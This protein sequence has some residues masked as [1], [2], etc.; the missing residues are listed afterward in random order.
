MV[1]RQK[2]E[3]E[4]D[5]LASEGR[6]KLA[7]VEASR[8]RANELMRRP[9]P[10]RLRWRVSKYGAPGVNFA[11][12][13]AYSRWPVLGALV[14]GS[15]LAIWG[16]AGGFFLGAFGTF[17]G[18][19]FS[20]IFVVPLLARAEVRR[21]RRWLAS[22]PF[23]VTGYFETLGLEEVVFHARVSAKGSFE[24]AERATILGLLGH[25]EA[26]QEPEDG[27]R[28]V[29]VSVSYGTLVITRGRLS[30]GDQEVRDWVRGVIERVLLPRQRAR[31]VDEVRVDHAG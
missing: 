29:T 18:G 19:W 23:P 5:A 13:W 7:L 25:V 14:A 6:Q 1:E 30:D 24:E 22:L 2:A 16:G 15:V 26:N 21:E 10:S 17:M 31:P 9:S 3:A 27:D 20:G 4:L 12:P 11:P 28:P 8:R